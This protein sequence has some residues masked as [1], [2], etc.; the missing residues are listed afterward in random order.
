MNG[1]IIVTTGSDG[2]IINVDGSGGYINVI[3]YGSLS[4]S[5]MVELGVTVVVV[6]RQCWGRGCMEDVV[7]FL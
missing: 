5:A 2:C 7:V 1:V 3:D 4:S 6:V